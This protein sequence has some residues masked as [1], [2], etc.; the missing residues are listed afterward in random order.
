MDYFILVDWMN[1]CQCLWQLCRPWSEAAFWPD[2][3]CLV[4]ATLCINR[5]SFVLVSHSICISIR[6]NDLSDPS[7][8]QW[9]N[10]PFK[11]IIAHFPEMIFSNLKQVW[12]NVY[13]FLVQTSVYFY[14]TCVRRGNNQVFSKVGK[15]PFL[16]LLHSDNIPM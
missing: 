4:H 7:G 1:P 11:D 9:L 8:Y 16:F 12:L 3:Q 15:L 6:A 14:T 5:L 2:C 10:Q 13:K